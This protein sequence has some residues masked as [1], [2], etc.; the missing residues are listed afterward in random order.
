MA[1][2]RVCMSNMK[3]EMA[4]ELV[5]DVDNCLLSDAEEDSTD[6]GMLSR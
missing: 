3:P 6:N 2:E 5:K 1:D 4:C